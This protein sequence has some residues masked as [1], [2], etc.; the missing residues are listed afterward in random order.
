MIGVGR[1][2]VLGAVASAMLVVWV[3]AMTGVRA[4]AVVGPG[5]KEGGTCRLMATMV[6]L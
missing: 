6:Q 5:K 1:Q 3:G 4:L 2:P